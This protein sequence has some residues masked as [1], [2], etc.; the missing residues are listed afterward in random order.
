MITIG[1]ELLEDVGLG[2]LP[3]ETGRAVLRGFYEELEHRVGVRLADRMTDAQLDEFEALF[4]AGDDKGA[5]AWLESS[6]P[7]YKL[8]VAAEFDRLKG[9]LAGQGARLMAASQARAA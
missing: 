5:F 7:D 8:V 4:E 1:P 6:F 2:E 9:E 3:R